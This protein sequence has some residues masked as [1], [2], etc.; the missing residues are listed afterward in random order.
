MCGNCP[1]KE[2]PKRKSLLVDWKVPAHTACP[3]WNKCSFALTHNCAHQGAD[4]PVDYSCASARGFDI[5]GV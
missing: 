5:A 2:Q 3:F 4:H 1:T